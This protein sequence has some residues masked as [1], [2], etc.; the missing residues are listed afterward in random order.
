MAAAAAAAAAVFPDVQHHS[1]FMLSLPQVGRLWKA[2]ADFHI[3]RGALLVARDDTHYPHCC[4]RLLLLLLLQPQVGR[5]WTA[6]ADFHIR[7]GAFEVARDVYEEGLAAVA[8]VRD[9]G[10]LFDALS[11][12]EESLLAAKLAA[13]GDDDGELRLLAQPKGATLYNLAAVVIISDDH[14]W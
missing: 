2:L 6:L 5:L 12:F 8:T 11:H 7:R 3:R 9:F 14:R 10:L 1:R 13:A 4:L